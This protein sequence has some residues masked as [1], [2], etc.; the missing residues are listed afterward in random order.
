MLMSHLSLALLLLVTAALTL[1]VVVLLLVL[2][3]LIVV[4]LV[5]IVVIVLILVMIVIVGVFPR[6]ERLLVG[7]GAHAGDLRAVP[8][9]IV[10]AADGGGVS[11]YEAVFTVVTNQSVDLITRLH[12]T[13]HTS[14]LHYWGLA[15]RDCA[16]L[17]GEGEVVVA[18]YIVPLSSLVPDHHHTVLSRLEETVWLVGTPVLILHDA[19][20]CPAEVSLKHLV[21]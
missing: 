6:S 16:L 20:V 10:T 21:V 11:L 15:A 7:S 4:L 9:A 12:R 13:K 8:L 3:V 5:S 2:V 18:G 14:I 17:A 19:A 1:L